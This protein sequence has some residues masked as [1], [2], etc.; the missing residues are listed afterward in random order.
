M[1]DSRPSRGGTHIS[2]KCEE[3]FKR[4]CSSE[5]AE[6]GLCP[7]R[8]AQTGTARRN[9]PFAKEPWG[10]SNPVWTLFGHRIAILEARHCR[11]L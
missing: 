7:D 4:K 3:S 2:V 9:Q 1:D 5:K 11:H 10:A 8:P 6:P